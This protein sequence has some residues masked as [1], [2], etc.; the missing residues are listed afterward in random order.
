MSEDVWLIVAVGA[1]W[2]LLAILYAVV[3]MFDMPGSVLIW[4]AG[5]VLFLALAGAVALA[6]RPSQRHRSLP[7]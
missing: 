5:A 2:A 4:G 1:V 7:G 6:E 3:P